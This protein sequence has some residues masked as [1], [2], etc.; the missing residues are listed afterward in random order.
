MIFN[1]YNIF[2]YL[3]FAWLPFVLFVQ[4]VVTWLFV[5]C[6][7]LLIT[8]FLSYSLSGELFSVTRVLIYP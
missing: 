5:Y 8:Y 1:C 6:E 3:V 7:T 2:G 4:G